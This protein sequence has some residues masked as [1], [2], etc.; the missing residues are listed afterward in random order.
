MSKL[1]RHFPAENPGESGNDRLFY[2]IHWHVPAEQPLHRRHPAVGDSTGHDQPESRQVG[3]HVQGEAMA[4]HPAR[5]PDPD[6]GELVFATRGTGPDAGQALDPSR[7][8]A[9]GGDGTD[10]DVLEVADIAMD[11]AAIRLE[12]D[13]GVAD[14]LPRP[15]VGDVPAAPG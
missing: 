4:R 1:A 12:I 7:G 9:E 2:L 8:D 6:C 10:Q 5:N 14:E 3:A 13:D 15:V 11:I